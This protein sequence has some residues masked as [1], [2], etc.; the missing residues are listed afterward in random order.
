MTDAA[1]RARDGRFS[2]DCLVCGAPLD[3][4]TTP[5]MRVCTFCGREE[6]TLISCPAGHF[7]CDVC[8]G[9]PVMKL[10]RHVLETTTEP[11]PVAILEDVMALPGLP[12]HG[13]EHHTIVAGVIVAA[14]RNVDAALPPEALSTALRRAGKVPG[15]W[16]GYYGACG[17]AV[18][19]GVAVSVVTEATPLRGRERSSALAATS[20]ALSRMIDDQ[21]RCCKRAS[22]VAV[23]VAAPF[24]AERLSIELPCRARSRCGF[25]A[26]NKQCP[27]AECPFF[28]A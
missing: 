5:R 7:V 24:F 11:D 15:G 10:V 21:P 28:A 3:Y 1:A 26:R 13:P 9:A 19:V 25:S 14:A 8:H 12:M 2:E 20:L 4:A 16:C 17:A 27:G 6:P 23:E 18:G 22:R